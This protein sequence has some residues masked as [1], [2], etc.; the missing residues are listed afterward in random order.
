[1]S[2]LPIKIYGSEVLRQK[3]EPVE[4]MTDDLR[5]IIKGMRDSLYY[6]QGAGLAANQIGIARQIFL[7][8]DG[9]GLT[10]CLNPRI[11][12]V[13]GKA[14]AEEG[15]LS[16]PEIYLDVERAAGLKLE[17]LDEEW[18]PRE[19]EAEGLLSR[20][21]QHEVDHLGGVLISDRAS[22]LA[23]RL[24]AGKLRKLEKRVQESF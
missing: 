23:R 7:A 8:D 18:E 1:M 13:D 6:H 17:Y 10:V 22:F 15:C 12:Q 11:V 4:E 5:K 14:V 2:I 9:S 3:A 24:I 21:I 19:L 16:L 20:I